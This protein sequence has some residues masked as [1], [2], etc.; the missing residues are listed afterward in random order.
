M[1]RSLGAAWLKS[2][3]ASGCRVKVKEGKLGRK[4]ESKAVLK[5]N[6]G[7]ER[8]TKARKKSVGSKNPTT[9]NNIPRFLSQPAK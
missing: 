4:P 7:K 2:L 6:I 8:R 5:R 1:V 9:Q 3:A